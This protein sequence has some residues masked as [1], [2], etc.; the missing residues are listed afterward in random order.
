M[1]VAGVGGELGRGEPSG[2]TI[3]PGED[4]NAIVLR[5]DG[6]IFSVPN[7]DR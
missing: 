3:T 4:G 1:I 5:A 6:G 7:L 2:A